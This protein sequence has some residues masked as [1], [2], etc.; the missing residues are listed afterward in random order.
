MPCSHRAAF[1]TLAVFQHWYRRLVVCTFSRGRLHL[2]A[3]VVPSWGGV[4]WDQADYIYFS[5]LAGFLLTI[6]L[7]IAQ[8]IFIS[9]LPWHYGCQDAPVLP[10]PVLHQEFSIICYLSAMQGEQAAS[11]HM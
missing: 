10:E 7:S 2:H 6:W 8:R 1:L 9:F 11:V 3:P 5:L 4:W